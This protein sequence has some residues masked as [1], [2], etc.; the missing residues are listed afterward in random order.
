MR[1]TV[2]SFTMTSDGAYAA[3]IVRRAKSRAHCWSD[4]ELAIIC[5]PPYFTA[6]EVYMGG[7]CCTRVEFLPDDRLMSSGSDHKVYARNRC[8]FERIERLGE[9]VHFP[10]RNYSLDARAGRVVGAD[11][12][13][14]RILMHD[15]RVYA[16]N[17]GQERLLFDGN[18]HS[19][20]E[21]VAPKWATRW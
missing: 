20:E 13:G 11:Q 14:R 5:R 2:D 12:Q 6:L 16:G 8:P 9:R 7:L 10:E 19:F 21:V 1:G 3:I 15:G 18:D 17:E 4:T